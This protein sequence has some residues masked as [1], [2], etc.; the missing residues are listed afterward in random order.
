M[1]K[2]YINL[3]NCFGIGSLQHEFDFQKSNSYLI[4]APNGTMKTSFARTLDLI[5]KN[6]PKDMP[7]DKI[8]PENEAIHKILA[9][10]GEIDSN[11]IFVVNADSDNINGVE[12]ISSFLA[13]E[14]LKARYDEIY[15]VLDKEKKIFLTELKRISGSADCEKELGNTFFSNDV[16]NFFEILLKLQSNLDEGIFKADFKYNDVFDT[17]GKVKAF[18]ETNKENIESYIST[19]ESLMSQSSF[20]KGSADNSFGTYQAN[21]ILK[22]IDD[23]AFFDAGHRFTL[24]D[25]REISN[26]EELKALISAEIEK[27]SEDDSLKKVFERIDK[28]ITS[29]ADLRKFHAVIE[30]NSSLLLYLSDYEIFKIAVWKG[31]LSEMKESVNHLVNLYQAN[32]Q[33]L[34]G[35]IEE[36]RKDIELWK[37]IIQTF[38]TRFK[39]PFKVSIKNQEDII[40]KRETASLEFHYSDQRGT[41]VIQEKN[42]LLNILSRGEQRAFFI[43]Q[44]LFALESRKKI[45]QMQLL[46]LDDIADSF[47]YK[48]K[49]AIIEYIQELHQEGIFKTIILTHNFDF[50]RTIASRLSLKADA[51]YM[52]TSCEQ[53][54]I[55]FHKGEYRRNVFSHFLGKFQDKKIFISLIAF[56]RNLVE[57]SQ[58]MDSSDY[59]TLTNCLH[60]KDETNNLKVSEVFNVYIKNLKLLSD[61]DIHFKDM[62][63]LNLIYETAAEILNKDKINEIYLENK[64]VLA[65]AIRLKAEEYM[66]QTLGGLVDLTAIQNNQTQELYKAYKEQFPDCTSLNILDRV[67]LMTPENIHI[68][69]FMY[70]PL[71]DMSINHLVQ[72][73]EDLNGLLE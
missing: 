34:I 66:I 54:Q 46:V 9:D 47:D 25:Q 23:N 63:V 57:Y 52:A 73:F 39:V 32:Q 6:N 72:L 45:G 38:N 16:T 1:N 60:V 4:Y 21:T 31:F 33:E 58:G 62:T 10:G 29:N 26:K 50:Y 17:S 8:Y 70:E 68:N 42:N 40:L 71:I 37:K 48:N 22:S 69:A 3:Q 15:A 12:S 64:I 5:S 49:F 36:A 53:K 18:L 2:V 41:P 51:A 43:L 44:F 35:I 61:K 28:A 7:S 20:F 27:I 24:K 55:I 30:K 65:I 67:N 56:V 11:R 19:Y 13:K 59:I 14:E